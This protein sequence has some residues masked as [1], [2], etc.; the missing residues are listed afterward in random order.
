MVKKDVSDT[1][2]N[3]TLLLTYYKI[4]AQLPC[5]QNTDIVTGISLSKMCDHDDWSYMHHVIC[6][7][8]HC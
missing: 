5:T 4:T 1:R 2:Y 6:T 3:G 8:N 7:N